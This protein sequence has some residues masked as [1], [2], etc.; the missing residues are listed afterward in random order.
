MPST[1][2]A[3]QNI[4]QSISK[5]AAEEESGDEQG[6]DT[7]KTV[8]ILDSDDEDE[9]E[10]SRYE[11]DQEDDDDEL[12]GVALERVE[13]IE[14]EDE[15]S[16]TGKEVSKKRKRTI[17]AEAP[18]K[19]P[20]KAPTSKK[21]KRAASLEGKSGAS[22]L[23]NTTPLIEFCCQTMRHCRRQHPWSRSASECLRL[24]ARVVRSSFP[25][26]Q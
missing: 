17:S 12:T 21:S 23:F 24:R 4:A 20:K 14:D 11:D 25:V 22:L 2:R 6:T 3:A 8:V 18:N 10:A 19:A 16:G 9:W 13:D 5:I 1:R 15:V 7:D 26:P